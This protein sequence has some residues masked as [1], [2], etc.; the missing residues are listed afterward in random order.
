MFPCT[1][2]ISISPYLIS[3]ERWNLW[4]CDRHSVEPVTMN[5]YVA[6]NEQNLMWKLRVEFLT[7][8][9]GRGI[10]IDS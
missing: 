7:K 10:K 5:K 2:F 6:E 1:V 3:E 8:F 4:N 9:Q